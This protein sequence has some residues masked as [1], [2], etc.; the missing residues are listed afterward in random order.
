LSSILARAVEAQQP[1]QPQLTTSALALDDERE[2]ALLVAEFPE[3]VA[4]SAKSREPHQL[5]YFL[6]DACRAFHGYYSRNKATARV[7][8]DDKVTTQS[9]LALVAAL[10]LVLRNG[11]ALLGVSAPERM[12]S[13]T[14][15]EADV[16]AP[17]I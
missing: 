4:R 10:Q 17:K 6:M 12:V 1:L 16:E 8:G 9:R 15:T 2:L 3:V 11:L 13:L 7:I 14:D 5:A